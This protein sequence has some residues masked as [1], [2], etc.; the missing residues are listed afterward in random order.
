MLLYSVGAFIPKNEPNAVLN[1]TSL[2][3][4]NLLLVAVEKFSVQIAAERKQGWTKLLRVTPL[5]AYI[6]LV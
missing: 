4:I 5:P 3:A 1:L 2:A 6:Y